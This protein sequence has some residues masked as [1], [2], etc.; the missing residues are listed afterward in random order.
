MIKMKKIAFVMTVAI[1]L[2]IFS[3]LAPLVKVQGTTEIP[4]GWMRGEYD[5]ARTRYYPYPSKYHIPDKPFELLWTSPHEGKR[6]MALTGDVNGDG[7]LEVVKVSGDNLT[8]ISGDG[9]V[10]W[11]EMIPGED[12]HYGTGWLGLNML[13]DVTGDGVQEIFV[14]RK[15]SHT[16]LNIYVYDGNKNR[17]KTLSGTVGYDGGMGAGAVFDVDNDGDKEIFCSMGTNYAGNPRGACLFDYDTGVRLWYY[18]AGN[19]I[20]Y[21]MADLNN[22]GMLEITSSAWFT[23]HNNAWGRGKGTA[24]YTDDSS[25]YVV[26]INE[27][28]DEILTKQLHGTHTHGYAYGKI[29]DLD[30]D[31][32]KEIIVFHSHMP[33]RPGYAEI[34]LW[35]SSGNLLKS[36]PGPYNGQWGKSVIADINKDGKDEVTV[37]ASDCVLRVLD[38]N[39]NVIDS[40][41]GYAAQF[42]NDINGDGE[43]EIIC[44]VPG[45]DIGV[46]DNSLDE[47]WRMSIGGKAIASDVTGDG[48]NDL[49]I[50]ND[51]GLHVFSLPSIEATV[52]IDPDTLNLKSNGEW[53]SAYIELPAGFD[54]ANIDVGSIVLTVDGVDFYVDPAA[55]T[56]IG[57]YDLDGVSD[58][59]VK[60]NRAAIRDHLIGVDVDTEDGRFYEV[61]FNIA[62]SV[63]TT[64]FLGTDTVRIRLP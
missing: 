9:T 3:A 62:G 34:F 54:V 57:D 63:D 20:G 24:T 32:T 6:L 16:I 55:P 1:V 29:V 33:T 4:G 17:I 30:R 49:I 43:L 19:P 10:L 39:L 51:D 44:W 45:G 23:V 64:T 36:F 40:T 11:T 52:D 8:V 14:S 53:I 22:D 13:E 2:T 38:S 61:D 18:A 26:V 12:S 58:L 42:A 31:G 50:T 27:N 59:M 5:L 35:D 7:K 60:F 48:V 28:G 41:T 46:L 47:L 37:R 25:V 15:V 21:S 56:A